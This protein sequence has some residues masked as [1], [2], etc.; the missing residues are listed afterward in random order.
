MKYSLKYLEETR[1]ELTMSFKQVYKSS[2]K[3]WMDKK[4]LVDHQINKQK[5]RH[6]RNL[7]EKNA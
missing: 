6:K 1:I 4:A 5:I 7:N 3:L 2:M